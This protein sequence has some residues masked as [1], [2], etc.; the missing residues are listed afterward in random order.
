MSDEERIT[1]IK[2]NG[3]VYAGEPAH[4]RWSKR[5]CQH[6]S[7]Y[8]DVEMFI[9]VIDRL[10]AELEAARGEI[11]RYKNTEENSRILANMT[12]MRVDALE[13]Q[14]RATNERMEKVR[15]HIETI[16]RC[17]SPP[18]TLINYAC[19]HAQK[20]LVIFTESTGGKESNTPSGY[21]TTDGYLICRTCGTVCGDD[22][23]EGASHE[24][25]AHG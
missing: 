23:G 11:E 24:I 9:R 10:R 4:Y 21:D 8:S 12:C 18:S 19:E 16:L 13:S 25:Q 5:E 22:D 14:L 3:A 1:E 7:I 2:L 17:I 15:P 6:I 20:A